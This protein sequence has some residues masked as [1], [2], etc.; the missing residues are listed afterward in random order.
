MPRDIPGFWYDTE[1]NRYFKG[2]PKKTIVKGLEAKYAFSID[3]LGCRLKSPIQADQCILGQHVLGSSS[4]PSFPIAPKLEHIYTNGMMFF[5]E[6]GRISIGSG[7]R[8]TLRLADGSV[9]SDGLD[10]EARLIDGRYSFSNG[11]F[12]GLFHNN[13]HMDTYFAYVSNGTIVDVSTLL[14]HSSVEFDLIDINSVLGDRLTYFVMVEEQTMRLGYIYHDIATEDRQCRFHYRYK[15]I[16]A[17]KKITSIKWTMNG[18]QLVVACENGHIIVYKFDPQRNIWLE[19]LWSVQFQGSSI[20]SIHQNRLDRILL[21]TFHN[22]LHELQI[23][24]S[25]ELLPHS[26]NLQS[27]VKADRPNRIHVALIDENVVIAQEGSNVVSRWTWSSPYQPTHTLTFNKETDAISQ[28][29]YHNDTLYIILM[30]N[31]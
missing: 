6:T 14:G 2:E 13:H 10:G 5:T 16:N 22:I 29:I 9:Q 11:L 21:V 15:L 12:I 25:Y 3:E 24:P 7:P 23:E 17:P 18:Q 1:T 31:T 4:L 8:I 27:I 26:I 30:S 20:A 19:K 28:I